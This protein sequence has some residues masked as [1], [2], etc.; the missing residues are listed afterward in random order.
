M[1]KIDLASISYILGILSIVFAFFN[2]GAGLVL[3]I[4]GLVHSKRNNVP[5][6]KRLC[7]IGIVISLIFIAIAFV[8]GYVCVNNPGTAYCQIIFS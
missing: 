1:A 3:G 5:E 7:T 2:Q 4:I 6:A 8:I